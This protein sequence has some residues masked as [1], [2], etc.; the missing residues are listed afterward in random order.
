MGVIWGNSQESPSKLCK[1][2]V[3]WS[4]FVIVNHLQL[5]KNVQKPYAPMHKYDLRKLN[6]VANYPYFNWIY[7][8]N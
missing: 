7:T 5:N 6:I 1:G 2:N 8:K 3:W 4:W